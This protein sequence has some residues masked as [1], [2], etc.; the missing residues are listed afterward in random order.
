MREE[1][2]FSLWKSIPTTEQGLR[3]RDFEVRKVN[4]GEN[5]LF[6]CKEAAIGRRV[7]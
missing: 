6:W 4:K 3:R 1:T 2:P 5:M 7:R